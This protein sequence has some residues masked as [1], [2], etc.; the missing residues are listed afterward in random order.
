MRILIQDPAS[1]G[2]FDGATWTRELMYAMDFESTS[3]AEKY[4]LDHNLSR[5]LVVVKFK[6]DS[7]DIKFCA[8]SRSS[9]LGS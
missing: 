3:S 4:C 9:L 8:G 2:F 7:D 6:D 5:A 1:K